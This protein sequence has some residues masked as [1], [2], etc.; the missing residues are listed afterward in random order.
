MERRWEAGSQAGEKPEQRPGG[1]GP[2]GRSWRGRAEPGAHMGGGERWGLGAPPSDQ[3]ADHLGGQ[4]DL[5]S[6][7]K[8]SGG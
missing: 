4:S 5:S 7:Y 3:G 8:L 1:T 6:L 2:L